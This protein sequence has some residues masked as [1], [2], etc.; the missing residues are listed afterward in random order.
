MATFFIGK[1]DAKSHPRIWAELKKNKKF[2][3]ARAAYSAWY[4]KQSGKLVV[5]EV[6]PTY[7]K[8]E[9][10]CHNYARDKLHSKSVNIITG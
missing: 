8:A 10:A 3:G 2:K 7:K 5:L 4:E 6:C 9:T 1:S